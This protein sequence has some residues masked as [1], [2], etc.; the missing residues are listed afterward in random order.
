LNRKNLED[1]LKRFKIKQM[2]KLIL[3]ITLYCIKQANAQVCFSSAT[4]FSVGTKPY[5]VISADF[6]SDGKMDLA[7]AN[8]G[9]NSVSILLG[10]GDGNFGAATNFAAGT[11][12]FSIISADFNG[13]GKPDLASANNGSN[14]VSVLIGSGTGSFGACTNFESGSSIS[15]NPCSIISE[16]FDKDGNFDLAVANYVG[17]NYTISILLGY[18]TGGFSPPLNYIVF[19]NPR[20]ITAS[21]FDND[22][23]LDLATGNER[24][25]NEG[26][27][28]FGTRQDFGASG[29]PPSVVSTDFN[30]DTKMDLA[31]TNFSDNSLGILLGNGDGSF[32]TVANFDVG[33]GPFS[34]I[35]TDFNLDGKK[36]LATANKTSNNVSVLLG[37]GNASFANYVNFS[38]GISPVSITSADFNE[39]GKFDLAI[40]NY[41]SNNV[42]VL[43]NCTATG[44]NNLSRE[45]QISVYPNPAI[46]IITISGIKSKT[47]FKIYDLLNNLVSSTNS[48]TNEDETINISQLVNGVYTL[49]SESS[50]SK[51]FT[52]MVISR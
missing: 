29:L 27:G 33:S 52:R 51:T 6:N 21:D 22:S 49:L 20:A 25:L 3:F 35:A 38:T 24:L 15:T 28:E 16:D 23:Y 2:K 19:T 32:G 34:I 50:E 37:A 48:S 39:D 44:I 9:S 41:N 7:T 36:D 31:I 30:G 42:S 11:H 14:N 1:D 17:L 46:N 4:N 43:L 10:S 12:P 5:S 45:Q 26:D 47:N 8:D 13:D 40:A 18:G